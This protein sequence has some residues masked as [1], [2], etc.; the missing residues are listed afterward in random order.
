MSKKLSDI[1][2]S[3][4][5]DKTDFDSTIKASDVNYKIHNWINEQELDL[6][7]QKSLF[8]RLEEKVKELTKDMLEIESRVIM[9]NAVDM[10]T[11]RFTDLSLTEEEI[12]IQKIE[13]VIKTDR[14]K[15]KNRLIQN[16]NRIHKKDQ[17]LPKRRQ[18]IP[19]E[20]YRTIEILFKTLKKR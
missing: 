4:E 13:T 8:N 14:I 17:E 9:N 18:K 15:S 5:E 1:F 2:E 16:I 12:P 11:L 3:F 10:L 7:N 19:I 6:D 20:I